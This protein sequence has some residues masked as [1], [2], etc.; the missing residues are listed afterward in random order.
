MEMDF[1]VVVYEMGQMSD[2]IKSL[3]MRNRKKKSSESHFGIPVNFILWMTESHKRFPKMY[4]I[5]AKLCS[6]YSN[7]RF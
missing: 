7:S 2:A 4:M 5:I 3:S 6:I 1:I